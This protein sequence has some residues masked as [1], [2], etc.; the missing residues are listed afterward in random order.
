MT[1]LCRELVSLRALGGAFWPACYCE[2]AG[3]SSSCQAAKIRGVSLASGAKAMLMDTG[4]KGP[5]QYKL[6]VLS[7]TE[8]LDYKVHGARGWR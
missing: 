1:A 6:F 4:K 7:A 8:R 2:C 5:D 3:H